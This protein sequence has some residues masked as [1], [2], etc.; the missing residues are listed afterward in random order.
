MGTEG[1]TPILLLNIRMKQKLEKS[2]L[3]FYCSSTKFK[4]A[5]QE[6]I[7]WDSS[8]FSNVCEL[9]LIFIIHN[10]ENSKMNAYVKSSRKSECERIHLSSTYHN[11]LW[12]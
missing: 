3:K 6:E 8:P 2:I 7:L 1:I 10:L 11:N 5:L 12:I 9:S 4:C